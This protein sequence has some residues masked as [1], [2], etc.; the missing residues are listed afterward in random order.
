M[1]KITFLF[2]LLL[3]IAGIAQ[4][5]T[6]DL[7]FNP[8]D[9]GFTAGANNLITVSVL[10]PDGKLIIGGNFTSYNGVSCNRI[11]RLNNDGSIDS[12]FNIGSG[13]NNTV[14][15]I[16]I[17]PDGKIIIGGS[18]TTYNGSTKNR[19]AR[20]NTDGS[21]DAGFVMGTG[22]NNTV[23]SIA[24]Q[25]DGKIIIGGNFSAYNGSTGKIRIA[26]LNANG[27]LD[28]GFTVGTGANASVYALALLADG[29]I[30]IG[31]AF[32]TF[33]GTTVN[34]LARLNSNGT[35]D[36]GFT[37]G[38]GFD[39]TVLKI[40]IQP[41]SKI[42]FGGSFTNYNSQASSKIARLN[43]DGTL[44]TGFTIGS[45][46]NNIV[47][48]IVLE[49][50]GKV[51]AGGDFTSF[52]GTSK[53]RVVRLNSNGSLDTAHTIGTGANGGVYTLSQQTD[54][55]LFIAGNFSVYSGTARNRIARLNSDGT[56]DPSFVVEK[57]ANNNVRV[58]QT[59]ADGKIL[60]AGTFTM[61][62]GV[63]RNG[64]ARLNSDGTLDTA[65]N[66]GV[67]I[68]SGATIFAIASQS[69]GKIMI[70]G[71]FISYNGNTANRIARL[72]S[73][74]TFDSSFVAG[75]GFNN[76]VNALVVQNDGKIMAGGTFTNYNG[77]SKNRI[78]RLNSNGSTDTGFV[79]GTGANNAVQSIALQSDGKIVIGG[80]F[81]NYKGTAI[82]RIAR[83]NTDGSADTGF[84]VGTGANNTI[85]TIRLQTDEKIVI[86]GA[87][88]QFNGAVL[89]R[90]TRLNTS[91][92]V[93]T[94]FNTSGTGANNIVWTIGLQADGKMIIGGQFTNF[95]G[96]ARNY[97]A[98]LNADGSIYSDFN[99]GSGANKI[100]YAATLQSDNKVL[101][102][103]SFTGYNGTGKNRIARLNNDQLLSNSEFE[104][105][106]LLCYPNPVSSVLTFSCEQTIDLIE[107][108][109]LNG[110]KV[111]S[112]APK[113]I[114][115]QLD[116]SGLTAGIYF[117]QVTSEGKVSAVKIIKQ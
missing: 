44:D 85:N 76:S 18:F 4:P 63:S 103:G 101:I 29:K 1:K 93:D 56:L 65:F 113:T 106:S 33:N 3:S 42:L 20:L 55:K 25:P 28:T 16:A 68:N 79:I 69:D 35:L 11:I 5:G 97:V 32:L 100:V 64:I 78:V 117:A 71:S 48:S 57:G 40:V 77:V 89:N 83:L 13:T 70:G 7:S 107:V 38:T 109:S 66:P 91:G 17:Q 81:T 96:T 105:K 21:L 62:N 31:G 67:G 99:Q 108:F 95:N 54:G 45:G 30:L 8:S 74:G 73:D 22:T 53:N 50:D 12:G 80:S 24:V 84:N 116:V 26:R 43:N 41:D 37:I 34:R 58:I 49:P 59:L 36:S 86:G 51:V 52:N 111:I 60:I 27:S 14:S 110:S 112:A 75:T 90:I 15:A 2:I 6:I 46:A 114:L 98:S 87:F 19:I 115:H 39:N 104:R 23:S 102:G 47:R 82:S 94:A 9:V 61:V 72:N 10:Q 92:S 88:T